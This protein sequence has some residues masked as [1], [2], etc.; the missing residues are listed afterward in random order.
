MAARNPLTPAQAEAILEDI[1]Q[2]M[3]LQKSAKKHGT[4]DTTFNRHCE[5]DAE[6]AL[7]YV[8]AREAQGELYADQIIEIADNPEIPSDHKRLQIDARKW[9][10]SKLAS[11]KYGDKIDLNH[12]GQPDNPL[13]VIERRIVKSQ[14]PDVEP[15][16]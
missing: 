14:Q 6:L 5:K 13:T 1:R 16:A 3:G 15:E 12:G 2:G 8:R 10:A 9:Q 4:T 7:K 11:K